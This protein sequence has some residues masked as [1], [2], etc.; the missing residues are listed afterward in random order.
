VRATR[1]AA[2]S[3]GLAQPRHP[4]IVDAFASSPK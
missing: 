3:R 1:R 4:F 2:R